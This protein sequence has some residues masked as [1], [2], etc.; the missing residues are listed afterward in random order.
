MDGSHTLIARDRTTALGLASPRVRLEQRGFFVLRR[1]VRVVA[2]APREQ[3]LVGGHGHGQL[4]AAD[5]EL[6]FWMD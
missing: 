2:A 3:S 4:L 6:G 5:L 1:A